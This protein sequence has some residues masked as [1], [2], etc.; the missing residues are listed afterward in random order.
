MKITYKLI[1]SIIIVTLFMLYVLEIS[2]N[3]I[4]YKDLKNIEEQMTNSQI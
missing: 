1:L 3:M 2:F 4:L